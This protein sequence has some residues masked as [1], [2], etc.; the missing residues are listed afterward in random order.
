M[1]N[2][3]AVTRDHLFP[4]SATDLLVRLP[5]ACAVHLQR[6]R[7]LPKLRDEC[8]SLAVDRSALHL[9]SFGPQSAECVA[10]SGGSET[11][12]GRRIRRGSL[13]GTYSVAAGV[14]RIFTD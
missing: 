10:R 7:P 4:G 12:D 8:L 1:E 3:A 14:G 6:H 11:G 9:A 13:A 2:R 5:A